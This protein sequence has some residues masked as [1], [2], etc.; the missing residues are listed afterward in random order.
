MAQEYIVKKKKSY[1]SI[2]SGTVQVDFN[3]VLLVSFKTL[4]LSHIILIIV[5]C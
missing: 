5:L 2:C 1:T 3:L 4:L